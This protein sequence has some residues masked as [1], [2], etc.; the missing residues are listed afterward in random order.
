MRKENGKRFV[1]KSAALALIGA[2]S[3]SA[4]TACGKSGDLGNSSKG[5]SDV[6]KIIVG[7]GVNY[8]PYCYLDEDGNAVGYEYAVLKEIDKLLP[9]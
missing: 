1:K 7:S 6:Q 9:Q 3:V 2:L 5:S 8:N 4:L